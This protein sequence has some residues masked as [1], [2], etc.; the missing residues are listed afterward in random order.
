MTLLLAP[1]K[2]FFCD[3][4]FFSPISLSHSLNLPFAV[5][6]A[7]SCWLVQQILLLDIIE[8]ECDNMKDGC[9]WHVQR[10]VYVGVTVELNESWGVM[11][12]FEFAFSGCI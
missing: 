2:G 11:V 10:S 9:G 7:A 12:Q 4:P 6:R 1:G 8:G 5:L 3:I